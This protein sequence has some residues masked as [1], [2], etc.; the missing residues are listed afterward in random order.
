ME[1]LNI[2]P[3]MLQRHAGYL[4]QDAD[5]AAE[6]S[7]SAGAMDVSNGAFGLL[8]SGLTPRALEVTNAA[9]NFLNEVAG[10]LERNANALGDTAMAFGEIDG[11]H[12]RDF[13]QLDVNATLPGVDAT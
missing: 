13:N 8:C 4:R 3:E 11:D 1:P 6:V 7:G 2:S 10:L 9:Q 5:D 12:A